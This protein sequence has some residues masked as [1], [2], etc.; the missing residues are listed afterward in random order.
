M[1]MND[2][3]STAFPLDLKRSKL[4]AALPKNAK[5]DL[6]FYNA[7]TSGVVPKTG[8]FPPAL[9][10]SCFRANELGASLTQTWSLKLRD[11]RGGE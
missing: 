5:M 3:Y 10:D 7:K 9:P 1:I 4:D 6:R 2:R 8:R 11:L